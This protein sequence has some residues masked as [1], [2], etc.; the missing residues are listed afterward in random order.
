MI[1]VAGNCDFSTS[2]P[3]DITIS[4]AGH[5][6]FITHGHRYGVKSGLS[7]LYQKAMEEGIP[8]VLFGHTHIPII[9]AVNDILFINPGCLSENSSVKSCAL[10]SMISGKMSARI[11]RNRANTHSRN[12]GIPCDYD[13][14]VE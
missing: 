2:I 13:L 7:N 11:V 6:I 8:T 5:E 9:Q 10:L 4:V 1:K 3:K 14:Q 12:Y